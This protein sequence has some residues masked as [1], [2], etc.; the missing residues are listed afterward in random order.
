M[1]RARLPGVVSPLTSG[2]PSLVARCGFRRQ[3]VRDRFRSFC[4]V[5]ARREPGRTDHAQGQPSITD[6]RAGDP[7]GKVRAEERRSMRSYRLAALVSACRGGRVEHCRSC[8]SMAEVSAL[9]HDC[10]VRSR[11]RACNDLPVVRDAVRLGWQSFDRVRRRRM[12]IRAYRRP[13]LHVVTALIY[14]VFALQR[15]DGSRYLQTNVLI[16]LFWDPVL[17]SLLHGGAGAVL[18]MNVIFVGRKTGRVKQLDL[19]HPLVVTAAVAI[20]FGIVGR[21]IFGRVELGVGHAAPI[22]SISSAIGPLTWCVSRRRSMMCGACCRRR[23]THWRCASV[24]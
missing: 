1:L 24:R 12:R 15:D 14:Q 11:Q 22:P 6:T 7:L 16:A 2:R 8:P 10:P 20:V 19:R 3:A 9:Q 23:S 18:P 21:R 5:Q 13:R 4:V 17:R